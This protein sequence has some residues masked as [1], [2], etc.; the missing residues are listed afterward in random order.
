MLLRAPHAPADASARR[1][2]CGGAARWWVTDHQA[3][4]WVVGAIGVLGVAVHS[5]NMG[6]APPR[7]AARGRW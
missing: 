6:T 5:V 1:G 2:R 4:L 3:S 7:P